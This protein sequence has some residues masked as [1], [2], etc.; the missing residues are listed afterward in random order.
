MIPPFVLSRATIAAKCGDTLSKK[1]NN[2]YIYYPTVYLLSPKGC[3]FRNNGSG[4]VGHTLVRC[5][6]D[7]QGVLWS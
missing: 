3:E 5:C 4:G 1:G 6:D 2:G 7:L